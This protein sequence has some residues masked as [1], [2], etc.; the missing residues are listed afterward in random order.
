MLKLKK[1]TGEELLTEATAFFEQT[2]AQ[3]EA[4][5]DKLIEEAREVDAQLSE[6]QARLAAITNQQTQAMRM[7]EKVASLII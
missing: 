2:V 4:A 3:L 5:E 1:K 6:L 7:R